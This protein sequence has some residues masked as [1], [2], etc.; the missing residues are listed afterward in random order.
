MFFYPKMLPSWKDFE[1]VSRE[2]QFLL[3][4]TRER[5]KIWRGSPF[6]DFRVVKF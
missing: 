6:N 3:R 2:G 1:Q 5:I 4:Q